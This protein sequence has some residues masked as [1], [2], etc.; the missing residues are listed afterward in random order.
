MA[1]IAVITGVLLI[2][3]AVAFFFATGAVHPTS[4][5]PGAFGFVLMA[6]GFIANVNE[7]DAKQRM[8]WMHI[9]VTVGLIGFLM[10]A[11]M[12]IKGLVH[13]GTLARV[14]QIAATEQLI[15]AGIC[16]IFTALCVRSFI[17]ARVGRTA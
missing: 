16:L 11:F 12:G 17:V 10:T 4:L 6:C 9:A 2:V 1:R 14:H 13:W 8:L 15:M 7:N 5:I 3:L